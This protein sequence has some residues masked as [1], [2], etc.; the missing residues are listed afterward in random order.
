MNENP[1]FRPKIF[2][3]QGI[4]AGLEE[5]FPMGNEANQIKS[6]TNQHA[7]NS[8]FNSP[9]SNGNGNYSTSSSSLSPQQRIISKPN[10][11]NTF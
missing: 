6:P 8:A 10:K 2:F 1:S 7:T 4:L 5:P 9:K 11:F 3:T